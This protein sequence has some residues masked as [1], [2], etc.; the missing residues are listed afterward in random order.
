MSKTLN[1]N[2]SGQ[3]TP[4]VNVKL[5]KH[6]RG[7]LLHLYN[8]KKYVQRQDTIIREVLR[9]YDFE[10]A[11]T[12]WYSNKAKAHIAFPL[13]ISRSIRASMCRTFAT[14]EKAELIQR[15]YNQYKYE[16][17]GKPLYTDYSTGKQIRE[18]KKPTKVWRS[19]PWFGITEKGIEYV[20]T[21]LQRKPDVNVKEA[22][23]V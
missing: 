7:V 5:G 1:V 11:K 9:L 18:P 3:M 6:M 4:D 21:S 17:Q 13:P 19:K 15:Q 10:K 12:S 20:N 22:G 23:S 14:L 2:N 16:Y 8:E